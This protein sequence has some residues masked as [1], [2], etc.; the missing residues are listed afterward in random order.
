MSNFAQVNE[1]NIVVAVIRSATE[2]NSIPGTVIPENH[3]WIRTS[4]SGS[5]R[6]RFAGIGMTYDEERDVFLCQKP[7]PSWVLN[8]TT[9][10]WNAP[11]AKPGD[12]W[13]WNWSEDEQ[14]WIDV[15]PT[16]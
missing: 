9:L 5:I 1:N 11:V 16:E 2:D 4:Y 15:R 6:K 8:E 7:F 10:E 12:E 3:R 14:N 13:Y